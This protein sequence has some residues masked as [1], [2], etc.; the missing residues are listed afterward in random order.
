M[1]QKLHYIHY[2]AVTAGLVTE[3][4]HYALS[5]AINYAGGKGL[6][7]VVFAR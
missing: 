3:P 6:I 1:D 2:N 7:D 4:H 5:S